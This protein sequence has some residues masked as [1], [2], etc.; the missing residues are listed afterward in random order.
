MVTE[1]QGY[2]EKIWLPGGLPYSDH[3]HVTERLT[4]TNYGTMNYQL[5]I[6]DPLTYT[7]PWSA[8]WSLKW[9][10]GSDPQEHYCQDNRL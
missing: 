5:T 4:R 10:E 9:L 8:S 6:N 7:R 1:S 3:M 2:N